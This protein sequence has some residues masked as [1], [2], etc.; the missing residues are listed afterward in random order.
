[1]LRPGKISRMVSPKYLILST[2]LTGWPFRSKGLGV[3][4]CF[5]L[6]RIM[7]LHFHGLKC[8]LT[9]L[10]QRPSDVVSS[11]RQIRSAV[12]RTG[13]YSIIVAIHNKFWVC[14]QWQL[15]YLIN[16]MINSKGPK[17]RRLRHYYWWKIRTW[18]IDNYLLF[19]PVRSWYL[20][21]GIKSATIY[22]CALLQ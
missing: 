22:M 1:M 19:S 18:S 21:E 10:A 3:A 6:N 20:K 13:P 16:I 8:R 7:A 17:H 5:L 12:E 4:T 2:K 15:C 9:E 14:S 11:C